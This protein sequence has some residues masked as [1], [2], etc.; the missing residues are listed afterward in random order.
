LYEKDE[1]IL[2]L[3]RQA[4]AD[5][6]DLGNLLCISPGCASQRTLGFLLW[7]PGERERVIRFLEQ[8]IEQQ[9]NKLAQT[10][11]QAKAATA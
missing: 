7:Q 1:V 11:K 9:K 6:R 3:K 5:Y 2:G 4:G 8:R 10:G